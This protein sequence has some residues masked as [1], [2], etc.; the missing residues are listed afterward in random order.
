MAPN[1]HPRFTYNGDSLWVVL[2]L[3]ESWDSYVRFVAD[4]G[5]PVIAEVRIIPTLVDSGRESAFDSAGT[6]GSTRR[7]KA[8]T[9]W[10]SPRPEG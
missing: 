3:D 4:D 10:R 2:A 9:G 7:W 1:R 6:P 5:H 8:P